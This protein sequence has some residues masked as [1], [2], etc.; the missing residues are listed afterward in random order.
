MKKQGNMFQIKEEEKSPETSFIEMEIHCLPNRDFK[1]MDIKMLTEVW[2]AMHEQ[3]EN[4]NKETENIKKYQRK[5]IKLNIIP[6][7][8]NSVEEFNID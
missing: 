1:L 5:I 8:K 2:R 3:C 4:S 6:E 7:L